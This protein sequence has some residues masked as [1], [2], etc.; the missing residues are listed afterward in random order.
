[1]NWSPLSK[2]EDAIKDMGAGEA[3]GNLLFHLIQSSSSNFGNQLNYL[4]DR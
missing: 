2:P 3:V 4:Q 1:M